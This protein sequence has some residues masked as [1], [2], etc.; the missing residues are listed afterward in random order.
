M[1]RPG[2]GLRNA[3]SIAGVGETEYWKVGRADKNEFELA[4]IAITRAVEDAGLELSDVDGMC[5]RRDANGDGE[6]SDCSRAR[7]RWATRSIR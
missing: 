3:T 6:G 5:N 2:A 7:S 4:C 1:A